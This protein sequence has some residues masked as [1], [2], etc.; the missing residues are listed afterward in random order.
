MAVYGGRIHKNVKVFTEG[1]TICSVTRFSSAGNNVETSEGTSTNTSHTGNLRQ[2]H[3]DFRDGNNGTVSSSVSDSFLANSRDREGGGNIHYHNNF[4]AGNSSALQDVYSSGVN[5]PWRQVGDENSGIRNIDQRPGFVSSI[6]GMRDALK[7]PPIPPS[8]L[9]GNVDSFAS[10]YPASKPHWYPGHTSSSIDVS[11]PATSDSRYYTLVN[12][13]GADYYTPKTNNAGIRNINHLPPHHLTNAQ[14]HTGYHSVTAASDT[15]SYSSPRSSIGSEGDSKNSSPRTSL[16]NTPYYEQKFGGPRSVFPLANTRPAVSFD[17]I[18]PG[19]NSGNQLP[20]PPER[21]VAARHLEHDNSIL[22]PQASQAVSLNPRSMSVLADSR[23]IETVP[24]HIYTDPRQRSL[25][26]QSSVSVHATAYSG[27]FDNHRLNHVTN[28]GSQMLVSSP[29]TA[30]SAGH[31]SFATASTVGGPPSIPARIPLNTARKVGES[32]SD[33]ERVVAALTQQLEKDMTISS[34]PFRKNMDSPAI[35][36]S[37]GAAEPPPPYHGPHDVQTS[38]KYTNNQNNPPPKMNV[39]LVAPVQGI[40][41]QTGSEASSLFSGVSPDI[42]HQLAFQMTPPKHNGPSDAEQK[43]AALTQ[44]LED[45]MDHVI[46]ADYFGQ[47]TTCGDKVTGTNQACQAMGNLYH[48]KCFVCCSCG[49]TLRGKAFYNVHGRVYCE[50]DYLYSGF[51][52]TAEKCVV[53]GHLIMEM[54]LQAMGKSYH[55]GCFRCCICNECLDGVPFTIDVDNKIYCVADYHRVYAPKCA[56]CGQA[57][58]P[59]D[60]NEETVRVVSMDKDFHVDC[61]HC[62]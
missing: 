29:N 31:A 54:I 24:Q 38:V 11:S 45:E 1:D 14:Y 32:N 17:A 55:P 61:F 57:I 5:Q 56:A 46:A 41:V 52:Q 50:E 51:Q 27:G 43:L 48:T 59:V 16:T 18:Q 9:G 36:E 20:R 28:G 7:P 33:A 3:G 34:L 23:F 21:I 12:G 39:R 13:N 15:S 44:Q 26:P 40:R 30:L 2:W 42:K 58:T 49:R 60:G 8:I 10:S 37:V 25:P 4:G 19:S 47:C 53:C 62:E 6:V 35:L 22:Y